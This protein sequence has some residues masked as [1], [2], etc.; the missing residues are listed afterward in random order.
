MRIV[1]QAVLS[2]AVSAFSLGAFSQSVHAS[3]RA[4]QTVNTQNADQDEASDEAPKHCEALTGTF[5]SVA[6]PACEDSPVGLCTQGELQGDLDGEYYFVFETL[7]P[8]PNDPSK[9]AYTGYSVI[10]TDTGTIY[11]EDTGG[12]DAVPPDQPADL[13]TTAAIAYGTRKYR[14]TTGTFVATGVLQLGT[15]E[16]S[17]VA[18]VCKAENKN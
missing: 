4:N 7:A 6:V 18:T 1:H 12:V 5:S 3:G 9:F 15:A 16:G 10:T 17:Y 14:K 11:T 2:L 13:E 8:D